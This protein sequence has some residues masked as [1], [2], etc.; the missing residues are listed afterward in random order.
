MHQARLVCILTQDP[1][2]YEYKYNQI[3]KDHKDKHKNKP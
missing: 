2:T 3:Y 1:Q